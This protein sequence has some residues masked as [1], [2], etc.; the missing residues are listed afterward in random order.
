MSAAE[1]CQPTV[2]TCQLV[3][4]TAPAAPLDAEAR[5]AVLR[6]YRQLCADVL[7][8]FGGALP[9]YHGLGMEAHFGYPQA[10]E[11][12]ARRAVFA[13]LGL[14][15]EVATLSRRV[16]RDWGVSLA[17]Q[18]GIHT[19]REVVGSMARGG[20][21]E[22]LALGDTQTMATHLRG[23]APPDT[24]LISQATFRLVEKDCV[25]AALGTHLLEAGADPLV[26]Y[27]VL[28]ARAPQQRLDVMRP[29]GLT[30]FVGREHEVGLLHEA[31]TQATEG[32]GQAVVL[33][34]EAGIGKS[35]LMQV[36]TAHLAETVH[37]RIECHCSPYFQHTAF[38][39]LVT[40]LQQL[41]HCRPEE[42]AEEQLHKVAGLLEGRAWRWTSRWPYGR[43]S[44]DCRCQRTTRRAP[45]HPNC[46]G[47][48]RSTRCWPGYAPRRSGSRCVC[49]SKIATGPMPPR[50]NGSRSCWT[51]CPPPACSCCWW[52]APSLPCPGLPGCI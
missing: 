51:R 37:T 36:F 5:L 7:H 23:C 45:S 35:R 2:L 25:C 29:Q 32:L 38:Y 50:W 34:G 49:L 44:W 11:D 46:S 30:P 3:Y 12:A 4:G 19:G 8:R 41:L 1:W 21:G 27:Q 9:Q 26:V 52:V 20:R 31:W 42:T 13:G 40:A 14:V 6:D 15:E 22:L 43:R 48:R 16:Q 10:H 28:Q 39:P 47:S 24:V 17:M 33:R 18:V